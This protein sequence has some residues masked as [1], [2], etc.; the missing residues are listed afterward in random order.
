L[1][2]KSE[3]P[4]DGQ[5]AELLANATGRTRP[6]RR[7]DLKAFGTGKGRY[8]PCQDTGGCDKGA[9]FA[10]AEGRPDRGSD[11]RAR[12]REGGRQGD[13]RCFEPVGWSILVIDEELN[14]MSG[15]GSGLLN[16]GDR[17]KA[18]SRGDSHRR[19]PGRLQ[20]R[21]GKTTIAHLIDLNES[22]FY[23]STLG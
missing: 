16:S 13:R 17:K 1:T 7:F 5:C 15:S 11:L 12:L 8:K 4:S 20:R 6:W 10:A 22:S 2:S 21:T 23:A 19:A 3:S 18:C 9:T 14:A